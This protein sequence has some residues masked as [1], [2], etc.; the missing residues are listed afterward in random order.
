[1]GPHIYRSRNP[2]IITVK[3]IAAFITQVRIIAAESLRPREARNGNILQICTQSR[4]RTLLNF[5]FAYNSE[6]ISVPAA[7]EMEISYRIIRNPAKGLHRIS[8][9]RIILSAS[10]S[11]RGSKWKY[12]TDL[13][14]IPRSDS[15]GFHFCV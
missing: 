14:A 13:Y 12:L 8:L 5:T 11:P 7:S 10:P 1:M 2:R 6:C 9:L 4:E 3:G 15:I